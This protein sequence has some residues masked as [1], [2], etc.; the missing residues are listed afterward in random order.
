M[1]SIEQ[2]PPI[3]VGQVERDRPGRAGRRDRPAA[4][5][6]THRLA[7]TVN[8]D[9]L[10]TS[11]NPVTHQIF[12]LLRY[13]APIYLRK[14]DPEEPQ[15]Q[16]LLYLKWKY[17]DRKIRRLAVT[18]FWVLPPCWPIRAGVDKEINWTVMADHIGLQREQKYCKIKGFKWNIL[19]QRLCK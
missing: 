10:L 19:I 11:T 18:L 14:C 12:L 6:S 3:W 5:G 2:G 9:R 15:V 8:N 7:T 16:A 4:A 17:F 1:T 13:F